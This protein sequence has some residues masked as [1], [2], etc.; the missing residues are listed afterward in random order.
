[1]SRNISFFC[2]L[3]I[4]LDRNLDQQRSYE[5]GIVVSKVAASRS[6]A[7]LKEPVRSPIRQELDD[8]SKKR[9]RKKKLDF[10]FLLLLH[11]IPM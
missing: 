3:R 2:L 5:I 11:L 10:F 6:N 4:E 1:M 9:D 7:K 8:V